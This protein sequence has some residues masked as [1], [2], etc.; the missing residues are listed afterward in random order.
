MLLKELLFS[1]RLKRGHTFKI[2][3]SV[4]NLQK[5]EPAFVLRGHTYYKLIYIKT[6]SSGYNSGSK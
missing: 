1:L 6:K 5:S 3:G 2:T 4:F